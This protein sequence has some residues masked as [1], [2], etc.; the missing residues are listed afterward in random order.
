MKDNDDDEDEASSKTEN[1]LTETTSGWR[2]SWPSWETH[3]VRV[4]CRVNESWREN[5]WRLVRLRGMRNISIL[6][7]K[8]E[9]MRARGP[10]RCRVKLNNPTMTSPELGASS[11]EQWMAVSS[12]MEKI[13]V[14]W[15]HENWTQNK[16]RKKIP[17]LFLLFAVAYCL[18]HRHSLTGSCWASGEVLAGLLARLLSVCKYNT[19]TDIR[20]FS[21]CRSA[22][23]FKQFIFIFQCWA[24]ER[25]QVKH[26]FFRWWLFCSHYAII[27]I[28]WIN[29]S[30][31]RESPRKKNLENHKATRLSNENFSFFDYE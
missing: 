18:N 21:L 29:A 16:K 1:W 31:K 11:R 22:V 10:F 20:F 15:V 5:E 9:Q 14:V 7:T 12:K 28:A 6:N 23:I 8:N 24:F 25:D 17:F 2:R 19:T 26:F 3:R 4:G 30:A 13:V 27:Y